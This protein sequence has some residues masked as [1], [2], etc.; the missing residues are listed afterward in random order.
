MKYETF[1]GLLNNCKKLYEGSV[2]RD[3][4]L[5]EVLGGDTVVRTD[6]WDQYIEGILKC[7]SDE[8]GDSEDI[9]WLFW[10]NMINSKDYNDFII[11]DVKYEGSPKNIWLSLENKLDERYSKKETE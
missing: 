9:D 4:K 10:E 3:K 7:I 2:T 5:E 8:Y 6:W 1:E 11:D